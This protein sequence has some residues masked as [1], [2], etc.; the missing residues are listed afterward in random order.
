M[1]LDSSCSTAGIA[2]YLCPI[3]QSFG[4]DM[5]HFG[6][7]FTLNTMI[8]L[9]TPPFGM[10]LFIVTGISGEKMNTIIKKEGVMP[11]VLWMV[12]VDTCN[13]VLD[14]IMWLPRLFESIKFLCNF[15]L[16]LYYISRG[17]DM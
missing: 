2:A 13:V 1:L 4:I 12:L 8:G 6:V 10:L 7:V 15:F 16:L 9:C 5:V 17:G 14:V 3:A 11:M